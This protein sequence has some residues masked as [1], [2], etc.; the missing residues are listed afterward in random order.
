VRRRELV[1]AAGERLRAAEEALDRLRKLAAE[2]ERA[3]S[4]WAW[5]TGVKNPPKPN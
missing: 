1:A 3:Y 2:E 5:R 4:A